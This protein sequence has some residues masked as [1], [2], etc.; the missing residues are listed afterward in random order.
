MEET[1]F[2][3]V[4]TQHPTALVGMA[5]A[6]S[7]FA[8]G[9]SPSFVPVILL[10]ATLRLYATIVTARYRPHP[11]RSLLILT[12]CL[13]A[14]I[15][16]THVGPSA[17]ALSTPTLAV[18]SLVVLSTISCL[19]ALVPVLID[20][21]S[22]RLQSIPRWAHLLLF[23]AIWASSIHFIAQHNPVGELITWTPVLGVD[24]Y[25]WIR[26]FLGP[27]GINW[28]VAA[29]A[30]VVAQIAVDDQESGSNRNSK[31]LQVWSLAVFLLLM[32]LPSWFS[33]TLPLPVDSPSTTPYTFGCALPPSDVK[34]PTFDDYVAATAQIVN[35]A[36]IVLWPEGAV[37]F[38][39]A[40]AKRVAAEKI[41]DR[42]AGAYIAV[43]FEEY[44]PRENHTRSGLRRNGVMLI[45]QRHG[46]VFEYYKR[47]LVPLVESF[48]QIP[49]ND[50]PSVVPITF[51]TNK[52]KFPDLPITASICLDFA[53]SSPFAD[54]PIRPALILGPARTW[55][56]KVATAM[57]EQAKARAEEIGS[58]VLW[59]DGGAGGISG[60]AGQGMNEVF[61]TGAGSWIKTIGIGAPFN[62]NATTF[63]AR[64]GNWSAYTLVWV[65]FFIAWATSDARNMQVRANWLLR[66]WRA[67]R[68]RRNR[69]QMEA[70]ERT[71]LLL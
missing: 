67:W 16:F 40:E 14:C 71:Q 68:Q 43:S 23:P 48:S 1:D 29:W 65:P 57:W 33:S 53:T 38:E 26:P 17:H 8:L 2:R 9:P 59:C 42:A 22:V 41:K 50:P 36:Q 10:I 18:L 5:S 37:Q 25:R 31:K 64:G 27:I 21:Y 15:A 19:L 24:A 39:S 6:L 28:I 61:Q 35:Q 66:G 63:Y 70:G 32:A 55:D 3:R 69:G 30:A 51:K 49:S 60:I 7:L 20:A 12:G 56:I 58:T 47:N 34:N 13:T 62:E 45:N 4:V 46:V 11:V 44:L 52:K 54:L